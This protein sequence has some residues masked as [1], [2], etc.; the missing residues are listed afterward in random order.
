MFDKLDFIV[1]KYQELSLKVSDPDVIN[2]QPVWQKYIKEMGEMEPIVKKYEEYK[3]AKDG[4]R[5]AKDIV[6]NETDEEMRDL[7]KMEINDLEEQIEKNEEELKVLLLPKDPNDE[8]NVILEVR[9]GTG[10]GEA[11]LFAQ[12]LLR[13]YMRYAERHRWKTEVMDINDTGIGGIKEAV[14]LI[15]GKGAYSR[16]KYESGVHRVQRVPET[17]SAGRVHTSAATVAVL[18]EVDDV[19]VDLNPNDV[20]VDVY[21]AS[22]NGGQCVNTTDSAVRLT[23]EPTGLVVTC[24]D[25]K[26]Q[27]KNKEKAFKVLKARLYD[28]KLQEQNKEISEA[29]KSQVGSGDRSERIRTFNFQQGRVSEHRIGLTLYRLDAILDGDLDEIIDGLITSDQAEKMKNF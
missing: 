2:D 1:E 23:H 28:L 17:E 19:E 16:L 8:K 9:A 11:A 26:S 3:K 21:R 25:E 12:D 18:P 5:D 24:Q 20:R 22:G 29:R 10:G 27:I 7:A 14:V 4:L 13:M 6:E 15:K